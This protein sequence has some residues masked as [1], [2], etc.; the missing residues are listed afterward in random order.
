M[1]T[2][3]ISLYTI[4]SLRAGSEMVL[5]FLLNLAPCNLQSSVYNNSK[6]LQVLCETMM[7]DNIA[8]FRLGSLPPLV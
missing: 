4:Y 2:D 1:Q 3:T 7:I 5:L 6:D 8:I